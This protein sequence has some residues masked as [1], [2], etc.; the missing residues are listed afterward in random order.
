MSGIS[1]KLRSI[2]LILAVLLSLSCLMT[3]CGSNDGG[4]NDGGLK[5]NQN[6]NK[7]DDDDDDDDDAGDSSSNRLS[8]KDI[9]SDTVAEILKEAYEKTAAVNSLRADGN[10]L[11]S[12]VSPDFE[13]NR[14]E[15]S[16][17]I[18]ATY[19]KDGVFVADRKSVV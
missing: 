16:Y 5:P 12:S 8:A 19:D 14:N 3:S 1:M 2:A 11:Q 10:M 13:S 4:D 15:F 6:T 18:E 9:T 7:N 17:E